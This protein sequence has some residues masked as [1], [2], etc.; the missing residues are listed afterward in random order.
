MRVA[1]REGQLQVQPESDVEAE[2]LLILLDALKYERPSEPE[3]R[4]TAVKVDPL[5]LGQVERGLDLDL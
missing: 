3:G 2:A 5:K 1:W 4:R